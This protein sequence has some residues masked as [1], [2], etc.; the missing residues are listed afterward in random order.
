MEGVPNEDGLIQLIRPAQEK[1]KLA[2]RQTAPEFRPFEKR[3]AGSKTFGRAK[4][5]KNEEGGVSGTDDDE[6]GDVD[7]S[8]KPKG[9]SI[10]RKSRKVYID[11][12][13]KRAHE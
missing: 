13:L 8:F 6:D 4:F 10:G 12:V 2:I 3:F 5:L 9:R 11:E 1:F 7:P